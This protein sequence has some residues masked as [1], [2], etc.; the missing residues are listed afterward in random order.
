MELARIATRARPGLLVLT[1]ILFW[2]ATPEQ[3]VAETRAAGYEGP[4]AV[5]KDLDVF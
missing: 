4:L 2:G 3:I 5:G 1:H